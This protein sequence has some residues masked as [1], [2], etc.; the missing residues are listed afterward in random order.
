MKI[1]LL[2]LQGTNLYAPKNFSFTNYFNLTLVLVTK[3]E[4]V[5]ILHIVFHS[6][7]EN[8]TNKKS[9]SDNWHTKCF[10]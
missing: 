7:N 4:I 3:T 2:N 5:L 1:I 8:D 9:H 10:T 6:F